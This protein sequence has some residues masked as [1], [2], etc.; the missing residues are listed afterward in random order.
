[1]VTH[2]RE[3]RRFESMNTLQGKTRPTSTCF[4]YSVHTWS[5]TIRISRGTHIATF[6]TIMNRFE[7]INCCQEE[8]LPTQPP[9]RL[10]DP[11][12]CTQLLSQ[13][14]H[15]SSGEKT[16]FYWQPAT[17]FIGPI[18]PIY[19]QYVQHLLAGANPSVLQAR[20]IALEVLACYVPLPD[21]PNR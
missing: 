5:K 2:I 4:P 6:R 17:R 20:A 15:W 3:S 1:V 21:L 12:V 19:D 8:G 7:K 18:S 11:W 13:S 16:S 10:S 9:N 14:K